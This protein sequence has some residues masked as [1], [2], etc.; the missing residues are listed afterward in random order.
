M[1]DEVTAQIAILNPTA[2]LF[3][4]VMRASGLRA[5]EVLQR[6]RWERGPGDTWNVKLEKGEQYRKFDIGI[7]PIE[8]QK[9]IEGAP[10]PLWV[11]YAAMSKILRRN[12]PIFV[13][14]SDVRP[15]TAHAWRYQYIQWKYYKEDWTPAQIQ[16][17]ICHASLGSTMLYITDTINAEQT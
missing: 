11:S 1:L 5:N 14:N 10:W 7:F 3:T 12:M 6:N 16:A 13:M 9:I 8:Y 17:E 4:Q 2:A 15:S